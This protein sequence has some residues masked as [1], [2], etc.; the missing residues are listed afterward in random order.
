MMSA[1]A[2][3]SGNNTILVIGLGI[4]SDIS[5]NKKCALFTAGP[6]NSSATLEWSDLTVS[7]NVPRETFSI[8]IVYRPEAFL[9]VGKAIDPRK[10][11]SIISTLQK[12]GEINIINYDDSDTQKLTDHL[13]KNNY[14]CISTKS[15]TIDKKDKMFNVFRKGIFIPPTSIEMIKEEIAFPPKSTKIS[16]RRQYTHIN[17]QLEPNIPKIN[18]TLEQF[19]NELNNDSFVKSFMESQINL[20]NFKVNFYK[21]RLNEIRKDQQRIKT[22]IQALRLQ[23]V[24]DN[25]IKEMYPMYDFYA[26]FIIDLSELI[27]TIEIRIS[28]IALVRIR[29]KLID[30]LENEDH[31]LA[32][33]V[34]RI[35]IKN[36]IISQ[37]YAFSKSYKTF[38]KSFNNFCL[39]GPA[40]IGK[41]AL[42]KVIG[43]VF[44]KS[45]ILATDTIKTISRADLVG[46]YVGQTAPRTRA[47]LFETLE[48][49]LFIDEAYQLT[50]ANIS[51]DFG[52]ESITEIVNFV[53]KF[54]G[55][56]IVIVAG[57]EDAMKKRFFPSNEGLSRRFPYQL[58]LGSY[59]ISEL[60]DILI[61][62]IENST[63]LIID[64]NIGNYLF[65]IISHLQN[66]YSTIFSNQAGDMLNLGSSIVKAINSSFTVQWKE[67]DI[68][69]KQIILCGLTDFLEIKGLSTN[70]G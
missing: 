44:S 52:S 31:G 30:A 43:Y 49:V 10:F 61:R 65:S 67:G 56:N 50:P 40:G 62:F 35:N 36:R 64:E 60:T 13:V 37:L 39:M 28:E 58:V 26:G 42:A 6:K 59:T 4:N 5:I 54:I 21:H 29:E 51:L 1:S 45:G 12:N 47:I 15:M 34:G 14:G 25:I 9:T 27:Q 55:M 7:K 24:A 22:K 57:Y 33:I 38:I 20:F 23:S 18:I 32:S 70:L 11:N 48:G 2:I 46:Q 16:K 19:R 3:S 63:D 41:T 66:T 8:I 69:N 53:D 17:F 68:Y